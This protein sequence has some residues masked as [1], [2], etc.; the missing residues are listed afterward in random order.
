MQIGVRGFE[1]FPAGHAGG[2]GVRRPA[3]GET[4]RG[5]TIVIDDR[6]RAVHVSVA[7]SVEQR[8]PLV[9]FVPGVVGVAALSRK[10]FQEGRAFQREHRAGGQIAEA[11][12][13]PAEHHEQQTHDVQDGQRVDDAKYIA[14]DERTDARH[15]TLGREHA[16]ADHSFAGRS[17]RHER[18]EHQVVQEV[19]HRGWHVAGE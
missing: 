3:P 8:G 5:A 7:A 9:H 12:M 2:G 1:I 10:F 4:V 14:R 6:E 15:N 11:Q 17:A 19:D 13:P 16:Q 18:F